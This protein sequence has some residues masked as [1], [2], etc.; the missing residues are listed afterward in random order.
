[1]NYKI[2]AHSMWERSRVVFA[3]SEDEMKEIVREFKDRQYKVETEEIE[4]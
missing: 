1:M 4:G 3:E 2:T